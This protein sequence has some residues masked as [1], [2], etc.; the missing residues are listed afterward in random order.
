[1]AL[2]RVKIVRWT[3]MLVALCGAVLCFA[4]VFGLVGPTGLMIGWPLAI[5]PQAI[6]LIVRR[7][8]RSLDQR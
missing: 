4:F 7:R 6:E 5:G 1:M 2:S 8:R 3:G